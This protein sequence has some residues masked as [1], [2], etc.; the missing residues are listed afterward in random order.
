[1]TVDP[2]LDPDSW[3]LRNK[4]GISDRLVLRQAE[5][6]LA[7]ARM[8]VI[9]EDASLPA[10]YGWPLLSAIRTLLFADVYE[11]ADTLRTVGISKDAESQFTPPD[12]LTAELDAFEALLADTPDELRREDLVRY[13]SELYRTLNHVHPFR[14]GNGR[15][16]R[17]FWEFF[18][19]E[20]GY[21]LR[22]DLVEKSENDAACRAGDHGD[23]EPLLRMFTRIVLEERRP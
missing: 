19:L 9:A 8:A 16:Q 1:M 17:I 20:Y 3:V 15:A 12:S 2:Y 11:W 13:L 10:E 18:C 21:E 5:D 4:L 22:W 7:G 14:E 6:D 23:L